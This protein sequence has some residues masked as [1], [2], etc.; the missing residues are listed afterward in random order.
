VRYFLL[1][2]DQLKGKILELQEFQ[3]H[4]RLAAL[5]A[6]FER[7][8]KTLG[9]AHLEVILLG[10]ESAE[11]LKKTH[12]RYFQSPSQIIGSGR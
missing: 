5:Q 2:Y 10:A 1:V 8:V 9:Q 7:E 6:R 12:A 4:E 3:A 11:S